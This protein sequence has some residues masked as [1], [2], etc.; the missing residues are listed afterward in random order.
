MITFFLKDR[1]HRS[2]WVILL[3]CLIFLNSCI[4]KSSLPAG[5]SEVDP[6][7]K[8]TVWSVYWSPIDTNQ[9]LVTAIDPIKTT[10]Q[11]FILDLSDGTRDFIL[12]APAHSLGM[13]ALS[14]STEGLG[15]S[16]NGL[17]VAVLISTEPSIYKPGLI[18]WNVEMKTAEYLAWMGR[19]VWSSNGNT[20]AFFTE[21]P[22]TIHVVDLNTK[23]DKIIY[24]E[25]YQTTNTYSS[26]LSWSPDAENIVFSVGDSSNHSLYVLNVG[27]EHVSPIPLPGYNTFPV[28][29]PKGGLIA[30]RHDEQSDT[31]SKNSYNITNTLGKCNVEIPYTQD[32]TAF[33]WSPDGEKAAYVSHGK[34]YIIDFQKVFKGDIYQSICQ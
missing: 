11:V 32:A 26:G 1:R 12:E 19:V 13:R 4:T 14:P 22:P 18:V 33:S 15:W 16:S 23:Q 24:S 3:L 31:V 17:Y 9:L 27:S 21:S 30:F 20:L 34:I 25:G 28:W 29:S 10:S 5:I 7:N 6:G 8:M 2:I